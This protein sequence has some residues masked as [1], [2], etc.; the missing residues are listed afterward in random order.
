MPLC[1]EYWQA[2]IGATKTRPGTGAIMG[3]RKAI[4]ETP[5]TEPVQIREKFTSGLA[6]FK[7]IGDVTFLCFY[8]DEILPP[9]FAAAGARRIMAKLVMPNDARDRMLR[10]LESIGTAEASPAVRCPE[11][12]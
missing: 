10:M 11:I 1:G 3:G 7:V 6:F 4:E 12:H 2:N 8:V 9:Q 5:A